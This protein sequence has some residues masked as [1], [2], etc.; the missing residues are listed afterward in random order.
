VT[1]KYEGGTLRRWRRGRL[2]IQPHH[3]PPVEIR[4]FEQLLK[5]P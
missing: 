1:D 4:A 2:L 5:S 3:A